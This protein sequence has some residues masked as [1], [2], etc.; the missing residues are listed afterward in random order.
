M[1]EIDTPATEV[2]E[3]SKATRDLLIRSFEHAIELVE[4]AE[5]YHLNTVAT[6]QERLEEIKQEY[7]VKE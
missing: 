5:R 3:V 4:I 2:I 7:K 1:P 6:L